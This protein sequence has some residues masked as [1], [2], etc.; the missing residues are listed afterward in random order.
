MKRDAQGRIILD[1]YKKIDDHIIGRKE[2]IWLE[3]DDK[4][5]LFKT[6]ASNY[7]IYAEMIA[8]EMAKQCGFRTAEYDLAILNGKTGIVTPSFLKR[9]DLIISGEDY[10]MYAN[11]IAIQNN[12]E[13]NFKENSIE[14]ILNA[15]AL[16]EAAN[17]IDRNFDTIIGRLIEMWCFDIAIMESDRNKT[18]WSIIKKMNGTIELA[19]IYDCSTMARL[20]TDIETLIRNIRH[21]Y[22]IYDVIDSIQYSLKIRNNKETNFYEDFQ[23]LC[24]CFPN[25]LQE[26]MYSIEQIDVE[27][28]IDTIQNRINDDLEEKN[29]EIP[30][31]IKLWLNKTINIRIDT[32]KKILKKTEKNAK[33]K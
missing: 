14:N 30:Y 1:E 32:M 21:E 24:E 19:P 23:Y 12:F 13:T 28:A 29:F 2:K 10:L 9:G 33:Q 7:E 26:I 20:N 8:S 25:E 18:N 31:N 4:K 5:Y 15:I 16:Q 6:G 3:K 11:N 17:N 22:Q 27:K